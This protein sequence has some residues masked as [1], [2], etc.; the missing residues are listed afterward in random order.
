MTKNHWSWRYDALII[1][2]DLQ[3]G[4]VPVEDV[5]LLHVEETAAL[6]LPGHFANNFVCLKP[7]IKGIVA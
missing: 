2:C 3:L 4:S 6:G 7:T 5:L 1:D